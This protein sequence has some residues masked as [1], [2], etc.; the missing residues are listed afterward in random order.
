MRLLAAATSG[1]GFWRRSPVP[2]SV[3]P[4]HV[5]G[6][7]KPDP[8]GD[9]FATQRIAYRLM[10]IEQLEQH[11]GGQFFDIAAPAS[12]LAIDDDVVQ[13]FNTS[14]YVAHCLGL[15]LDAFRTPRFVLQDPSN[16]NALRVPMAGCYPLTRTALEA[17]AVAVFLLQPDDRTERL[18]RS[19]QVRWSDAQF[20]SQ[21]LIAS[22]IGWDQDDKAGRAMKSKV[23]KV[24]TQR[25][26]QRKNQLREI[27]DAAGIP[28]AR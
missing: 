16:E 11:M 13:P 21:L 7:V 28:R 24:N 10:L 19:L 25:H 6:A 26:R 15:G 18:T 9:E 27:A 4:E 12:E 17:A 5:R 2:D 22:T 14:H 20:D 23:R 8:E 1:S 3:P